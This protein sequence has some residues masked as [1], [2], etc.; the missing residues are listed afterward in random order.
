MCQPDN[1]YETITTYLHN[2]V[3]FVTVFSVLLL[4][5]QQGHKWVNW[6]KRKKSLPHKQHVWGFF[7]VKRRAK[8][9]KH[10][11]S[12]RQKPLKRSTFFF[13]LIAI[14]TLK[15]IQDFIW[16]LGSKIKVQT[17][18]TDLNWTLVFLYPF[19]KFSTE[20]TKTGQFQNMND[21]KKTCL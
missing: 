17:L 1:S 19:Q 16:S 9:L 21:I 6:M 12:D 20:P 10:F 7:K 11:S 14:H 8:N 15:N 2:N 3:F 5:L 18:N 13:C 4:G